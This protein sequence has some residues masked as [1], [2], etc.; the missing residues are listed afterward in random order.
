MQTSKL[1]L[2]LVLCSFMA[3]CSLTFSRTKSTPRPAHARESVWEFGHGAKRTFT[4]SA[5]GKGSE[6]KIEREVYWSDESLW[7]TNGKTC[8][9]IADVLP[10]DGWCRAYGELEYLPV[11]IV[12]GDGREI[13]WGEGYFTVDGE[14][15]ETPLERGYTYMADG[16]L[17]SP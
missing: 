15:Y 2:C 8:I 9:C 13:V 1:P 4:R 5:L 17:I 16:L 11:R 7:L 10:E 12:L 14:R 3:G 6:E